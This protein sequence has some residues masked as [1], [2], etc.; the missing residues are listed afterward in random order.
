MDDKAYIFFGKFLWWSET[1][2][3]PSTVRSEYLVLR[4]RPFFN[5][6]KFEEYQGTKLFLIC[7]LVCVLGCIRILTYALN[8]VMLTFYAF[9]TTLTIS[10]T[11]RKNI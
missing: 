3:T 9:V 10:L 5:G 6:V 8:Q 2:G 11:V 4:L 1:L 7:A